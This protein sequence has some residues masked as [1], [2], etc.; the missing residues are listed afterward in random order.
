MAQVVVTVKNSHSPL[1]VSL[2]MD[3]GDDMIGILQAQE[4]RGEL[5]KVVV[6]PVKPKRVTNAGAASRNNR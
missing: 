4:A 6:A 2:L 1:T 5:E 3:D